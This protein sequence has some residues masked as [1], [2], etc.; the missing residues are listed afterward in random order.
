MCSWEGPSSSQG[1]PSRPARTLRRFSPLRTWRSDL[2][3]NG[4]LSCCA[5][6]TARSIDLVRAT[7]EVADFTSAIFTSDADHQSR[8]AYT[9]TSRTDLGHATLRVVDLNSAVLL[10]DVNH[11][12]RPRQ[13]L[14]RPT[15]QPALPSVC[16]YFVVF[17][18]VGKTLQ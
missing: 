10:A 11:C 7:L 5:A 15:L 13:F 12:S 14:P 16:L 1:S 6:H 3:D 4:T 2:R 17:S 8:P 18:L 9:D